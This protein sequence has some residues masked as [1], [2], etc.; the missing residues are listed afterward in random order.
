MTIPNT[1]LAGFGA[2]E[3]TPQ[4]GQR[5]AGAYHAY[6]WLA[7][8]ELL[9]CA[10]ILILTLGLRA[11]LLPWLPIPQPMVHDEFSYLLAAD[12]Y[13]HGRL[14]NPPHPFWEHF[15]TFQEL[16]QPTYSSKYQ[17]LQGLVLAFGQRFFGE[18]WI[19][20]YLSAALMCAAICWMLQGWIA[21]E[22]AL[23]G[24]LFFTLR[25]GVLSYWMNSYFPGA[26]AGLGGA[27]ALGA[28]IRIWR[29]Q[30]FGHA[31]TWA[32]GLTIVALARPYDAAVLASAT[33]GILLFWLIR[34][35]HTPAKTLWLRVALPAAAILTLCA[36][37]IG[38]NNYRVTGHVLTLPDQVFEREYAVVRMGAFSIFSLGHEPAYHH[39]AMRMLFVDASVKLWA[40][41][42]NHPV[43]LMFIKLYLLDNFFFPFWPLLIPLLLCP[44]DLNTPEER[45]TALLLFV[46]M[47]MIAPL[48][49]N[50]PHYVAVFAGMVY[51]R[52]LQTLT[53][54]RSWHPSGK[55]LGPAL[56]AALVAVLAM[57][58]CFNFFSLIH[59]GG[60]RD[61]SSG[62]LLS[63]GAP[64]A[65]DRKTVIEELEKLPR[66]HLVL[67]RYAPEHDPH[68][69]WVFNGADINSSLI[70]WAREMGPAQDGPFLQY[71]HNRR[72]WLL[73]PD[74]SPPQ[75]TPYATEAVQ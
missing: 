36:V 70:V 35:V 16:Q 2:T 65:A 15:E 38:Y 53:R 5:L 40:Y 19:G 1:E 3:H 73:E 50:Q 56:S 47:A 68:K 8:R 7:S 72:I 37:G 24:A 31:I 49:T 18:P 28:L 45:A 63:Q 12:T 46:A 57:G 34:K 52:F 20:V 42:R 62:L 9:A 33:A 11:A 48:V 27:L 55:P 23:L 32:V 69:E 25:V 60:G 43:V 67:V 21:P 51:L 29:R 44:Y 13:V 64:F 61:F 74:R 66:H 59:N 41:A 58:L 10:F 22:W 30:Q 17:P 26:I 75:L 54:L 39:A 6:Q 4:L 71:F 14:A